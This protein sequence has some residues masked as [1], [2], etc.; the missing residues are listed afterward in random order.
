M[1]ID[2]IQQTQIHDEQ[3]AQDRKIKTKQDKYK[4]MA[5]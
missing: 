1:Q 4:E 2:R 3:K 5:R